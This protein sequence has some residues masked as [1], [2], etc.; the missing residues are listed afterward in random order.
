MVL[1]CAAG[2]TAMTVDT[3]AARDKNFFI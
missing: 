1:A 2:V 3:A